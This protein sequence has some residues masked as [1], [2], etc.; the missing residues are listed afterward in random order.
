[1]TR[2]LTAIVAV[3]VVIAAGYLVFLN[4][5]PVVVRLTPERTASAPLAVALLVAFAAGGVVVALVATA[6]AS[7]RGLRQW[8]QRRRTRRESR[9]RESTA[10]AQALVWTGDYPQARAELLRGG[11]ELPTD[12]ARLVLL[13]ETYLH[14]Q[15]PA[16]AR[17]LLERG[18]AR[19]MHDA[20]LVDLLAEACERMGDLHA[21]VAALERARLADPSS[22]RVARRLRDVYVRQSRASDA[23]ALQGEIVLGVRSPTALA[24]EERTLRALRYEAALLEPDPARAAR[25]VMSIARADPDFVPAWVSAGDL[26]LRAGRRFR[27]RRAW[28]RGARRR[29]AAVLLE[30]I[31]RLNA[32]DGQARRTDRLYALLARLHPHD[33]V[34][35]LL[36]ARALVAANRLAD[37]AAILKRLPEP[38]AD[39]AAAHV[40]W[41]EVHRHQGNHEDATHE[42]AK[43]LGQALGLAPPYRCTACARATPD[44]T[45]R[46]PHCGQWD[47]LRAAIEAEPA[48]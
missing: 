17:A 41:A 21:A 1:M 36:H 20:R 28:E 32:T 12:P 34:L 11:E 18:L 30:R 26:Y 42:Y 35:P 10:R 27:A 8:R 19:G 48:V 3:L 25:G 4:A 22:P 13:A 2:W 40:L 29:P 6:R 44:W 43:A 23:L 16:A 47:T 14:E 38:D 24:A 31:E 7:A 9:R 39:R 5:A 45:A 15:E 33:P 37:A 46:C